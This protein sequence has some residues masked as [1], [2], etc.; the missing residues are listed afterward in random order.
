MLNQISTSDKKK[1]L[2]TI[3]TIPKKIDIVG[4]L[5]SMI[6][7]INSQL[8]IKK[9]IEIEVSNE[10]LRDSIIEI[11]ESRGYDCYWDLKDYHGSI[12]IVK[13]KNL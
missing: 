8:N 10:L 13:V 4:E 5:K 7:E 9:I 6:K 12:Y 1:L 3:C 11:Y 2:E